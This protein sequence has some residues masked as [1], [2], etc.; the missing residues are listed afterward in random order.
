MGSVTIPTL[1][2]IMTSA[3]PLKKHV[4]TYLIKT[5]YVKT[6]INVIIIFILTWLIR[7]LLNLILS[8]I[9]TEMSSMTVLVQIGQILISFILIISSNRLRQLINQLN[10][11]IYQFTR[12]LMNNL[13]DDMM[14]QWQ[15]YI[16]IVSSFCMYMYCEYI[17]I[18]SHSLQLVV[19]QTVMS[20]LLVEVWEHL[21]N[22]YVSLKYEPHGYSYLDDFIIHQNHSLLQHEKM[23]ISGTEFSMTYHVISDFY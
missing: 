13:N 21:P 11:L 18:T 22:P 6:Q 2:E 12:Y 16:F 10:P 20:F 1:K 8:W 23:I 9:L 17:D 14:R 3:L 5:K 4:F 19:I 7:M 15:R